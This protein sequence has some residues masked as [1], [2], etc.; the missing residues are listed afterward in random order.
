MQLAALDARRDQMGEGDREAVAVRGGGPGRGLV[1]V[2]PDPVLGHLQPAQQPRGLA[3]RVGAGRV[4]QPQRA[5]G[6]SR[7][8]GYQ[9]GAVDGLADETRVVGEAG[10]EGDVGE[11]VVQQDGHLAPGD[12]PRAAL[13]GA[14]RAGG[15]RV[16]QRGRD[17]LGDR[18]DGDDPQRLGRAPGRA[19]RA[20]RLRAE[21]HHLRRDRQQ[22]RAALGQR[23]PAGP[24]DQQRV[25][26][27]LAQRG[28][29][30]RHGGLAHVQRP[31]RLL[32]RAEPG[33]EDESAEL[34][35][36]HTAQSGPPGAPR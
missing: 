14:G 12:D 13:D 22:A 3:A 29:R 10:P 25:A 24:A 16:Q 4:D 28:Q 26:E 30:L 21:H 7:A 15:E 6:G 35:Q 32:H 18:G 33:D 23:H 27:V 11:A 9:G 31:R 2:D 17:E 8:H 5:R 34:R 20:L 19:D 36:R 1:G